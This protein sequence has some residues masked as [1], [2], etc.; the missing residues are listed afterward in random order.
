MKKETLLSIEEF[1]TL[2][3][4]NKLELDNANDLRRITKVAYCVYKNRED[5]EDVFNMIATKLNEKGCLAF[6]EVAKE[7]YDRLVDE[8]S[9]MFN[10]DSLHLLK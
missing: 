10:L 4:M 5:I 9:I 8:K 2:F 6:Q 3:P 7:C 1:C